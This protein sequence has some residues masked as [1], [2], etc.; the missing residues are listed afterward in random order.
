MPR[1]I[2]VAS[3]ASLL[4][5]LAVGSATRAEEVPG[6]PR[7]LAEAVSMERADGLPITRFYD[8]PSLAG[9]KPGD[10]LRH[11]TFAGY[12]LPKGATAVR[13][14]Y[15]SLNADGGD[16][17]TS[18]VVL[19]PRGAA[20]AGGWPVIA[21]A[22][23]TSGVARMCAPSLEKDMEYGEEG[24]MPMVRAGFAVVATDY[25][26]L[27]T[28]GP[29]EYINKT[30][31]AR[32]TIYSVPAARAAVPALGHRWVAVGH[33]Q[34][35]IAAWS[36][37]EL[38]TAQKDPDYLGAISVAGAAEPRAILAAMGEPDSSAAFYLDYIAYAIHVRT[39]AFK[40]ADML[41]DK[42]LERYA[43]LTTK[44]CWNYAYA[45]FLGDHGGKVLK[46]GW[47]QTEGA[48]RFFKANELGVAP[49]GGPLL[50]LAGEADE[51][52]PLPLVKATVKKA[53]ANGITLSFRS[54]PG[55]DHDPTMEKS[56][57]DQLAWIRDRFAGKPFSG[58]CASLPP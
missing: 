39:P 38:E 40:P 56:T 8:T 42:A 37:A 47:D 46:P 36:V 33:S 57:P 30:A 13:I 9:T 53:C 11:E 29:H 27:G 1:S 55:L 16:V 6:M 24:L 26:G 44:G 19:I 25:H 5:L 18:G 3:L 23:G 4:V 35:G 43:D 7:S 32:D 17:A 41:V 20:P 31:Q 22:H 28:E 58:N 14:L 51:T 2:V 10:L 48:Q 12:A 50:V 54:Y 21:W 34:G 52:V 45:S 49:V 15:H